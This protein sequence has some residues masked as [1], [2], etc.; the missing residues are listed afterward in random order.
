M[1]NITAT[2]TYNIPTGKGYSNEG[3]EV[4]VPFEYPDFNGNLADAIAYFNGE[5][6]ACKVLQQT[7]K[8]DA[9]NNARESAKAKNGHKP[10]AFLSEEQKA[11]NATERKVKAQ[12]ITLMLEGKAT[13]AMELLNSI[14]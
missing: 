12:A 3:K 1:K 13:E 2:V 8:E 5:A 4:D 7:A 9:G 6:G 11:K 14:A 10:Q